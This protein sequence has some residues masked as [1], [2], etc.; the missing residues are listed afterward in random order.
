MKQIIILVF[1]FSLTVSANAQKGIRSGRAPVRTQVVVAAPIYP[2]WGFGY[3]FGARF[4]PFFSPF[5][6]PFYDPFYDPYNRG[7]ISRVP[8]EL[9]LRLDE[10]ENDYNFKV[11]SARNEKSVAGKERRQKIRELKYEREAAL[12]DARRNFLKKNNEESLK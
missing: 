1:A 6:A 5:N 7:R 12:I 9:Q 2:S 3:G 4:S 8:A 11:S 10:I